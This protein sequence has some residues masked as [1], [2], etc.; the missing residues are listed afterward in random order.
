VN[1]LFP[2]KGTL[3]PGSDADIAVWDPSATWTIEP[4]GLHMETDYSAFEG[5]EIVGRPVSVLV[6]GHV[7]IDGG[8]LVDDTPRGR[9]VPAS[10]VDLTVF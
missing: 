5:M 10:T 9:H 1:G 4:G 6:R 7:V 3:Q 2:Q 8:E